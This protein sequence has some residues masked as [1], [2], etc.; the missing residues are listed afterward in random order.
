MKSKRYT[1]AS[2][3]TATL[4]C[5]PESQLTTKQD[6]N[7]ICGSFVK[8]LLTL[9]AGFIVA[10]PLTSEAVVM[11]ASANK[12]TLKDRTMEEAEEHFR[13]GRASFGVAY[14]LKSYDDVCEGGGDN[15][16]RYLGTVGTI[17]GLFGIS[18]ALKKLA[19]K[20]DDIVE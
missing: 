13:A 10:N 6:G 19:E 1:N 7:T 18:K 9:T 15:V 5:I 20:A 17:S 14:L 3:S 16:R 2:S 4:K 8:Y 12:G 11:D